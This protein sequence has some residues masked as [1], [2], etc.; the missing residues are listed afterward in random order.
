MG[1]YA[2]IGIPSSAQVNATP[3]SKISVEKRDKSTSTAEILTTLHD[4]LGSFHLFNVFV[5][6]VLTS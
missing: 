5:E 3:F 4:L 6:K 2:I 1:E